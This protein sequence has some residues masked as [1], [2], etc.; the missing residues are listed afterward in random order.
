MEVADEKDRTLEVEIE[1]LLPGGVGLAHAEGLTLFV[2]LAAPGDVLRIRIDRTQ[3]R[4]GFASLVE[5]IKPSP[6]R[7]E[8]PCPYFGRCG[9]CD[10]Q[11]LTYEAQLE[12][13]VEIIRD[14]L[15]RIARMEAP[16][17]EIPITPSANQWRYRARAMWQVDAQARLLGYF[18][19]GS[20]RVCDVEYCAVLVPELQETLEQVR[21]A[22]RSE[23]PPLLR[24]IEAVVGDGGVSVAPEIAGFK[25]QIVSRVIGNETYHFSADSFFQINQELL[26][27]L[28][29]EALRDDEG[30]LAIDLYC[31]VGLF[32]LP[33]A[34]RF[35]R[36]V[37]VEGNPHAGEFARRNLEF[38]KLGSSSTVTDGVER[39]SLGSAEIV[40]ARVG[41]WL[42]Q[43]SR[44]FGPVD[45]LLLDPP[46]SGCENAVIAGIL[47]LRPRKIAYVSCDPATLARDLKKLLDGGYT[48]DSIVAFDMF[49]QTHHV[50]TVVRLLVA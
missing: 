33:L 26:E 28:I 34:R 11:Q 42:K 41:D 7:V 8:P 10:F 1:R 49:P 32:T 27:A 35:E 20:N 30:T 19:R 23:T 17:S 14:C 6:V 47:A 22:I 21:N 13:K 2:S 9:G 46:R 43:H 39:G 50:E 48:L 44:A 40:T 4:V 16:P 37:G 15:H 3:G 5:I 36:V 18:E 29:A 31:G 24:D 45:F 38:A 12:A 25:T